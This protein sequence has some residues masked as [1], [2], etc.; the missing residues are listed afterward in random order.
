VTYWEAFTQAKD[1]Q[2]PDNNEDRLI[3]VPDRL[4]AVV[5]GATDKSGQT[6][7]GLT[8]GQI[9][10]R[11]LEK[12]LRDIARDLGTAEPLSLA[13]L[14]ERITGALAR[15]YRAL[16]LSAAM[17]QNPWARFSAQATIVIRRK[18]TYRF[19]VIGDTGLRINRTEAFCGPKAGDVICGHLRAVVH[20]HLSTS[21]ASTKATNEIARQYTVEGLGAVL[22]AKPGGIGLL[23]LEEFRR[24]VRTRCL[25]QLSG[26]TAKDID[27]VLNF[28]LKGL[29]RFQN[30]PGPLGFPCFDG[31]RIPLDMVVEFERSVDAVTSIELFS[32]GYADLPQR[33][34]VA[35][36]EAAYWKLERDDPQRVESHPDTKGSTPEKFADDRTVLIVRPHPETNRQDGST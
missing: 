19:I 23:D 34:N 25:N 9:A 31:T 2:N 29:Y 36:W 22:P 24:T 26:Q 12:V 5:D 30:Q 27:T 16:G 4:Y 6:H 13:T 35:D 32:D 14:L 11:V 7:D 17:R 1:R 15:R 20:R 3:V 33:A 18:G 21:G 28:G 8:G 10:G